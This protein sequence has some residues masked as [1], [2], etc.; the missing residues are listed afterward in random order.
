MLSHRS[1]RDAKRLS[2]LRH[3]SWTLAQ[4]IQHCPPR[5]IS[6]RMKHP[7]DIHP[8]LGHR[9]TFFGRVRSCKPLARTCILATNRSMLSASR[10]R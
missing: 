9:F 2:Q 3:R 10:L 5:S 1:Q 6:E 7:I 8:T 4:P